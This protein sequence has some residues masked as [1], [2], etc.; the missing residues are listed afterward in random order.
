MF[1]SERLSRRF[2]PFWSPEP[3]HELRRSGFLR[4][5]ERRNVFFT[6]PATDATSSL[7]R[8]EEGG[9]MLRTTFLGVD[10]KQPA[11]AT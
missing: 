9:L 4:F 1:A 8:G 10:S 2:H 11:A 6:C 3:R 7:A 5:E